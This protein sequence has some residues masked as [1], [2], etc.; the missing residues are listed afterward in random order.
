[1]GYNTNS[2]MENLICSIM[3]YNKGR[4]PCKYL[5]IALEEGSKSSKVCLDT[6]DKLDKRIGSWKDKWLSKA[7]K[8]TK[9][10]S[11]LS[12]IPTFPLSCLPLSKK[13]LSKFEGKLRNFLWKDCEDDTKLSLVKW[14][15]LC[16]PKKFGG[17]GVKN[18]QWKNEALGVKIIWH[19]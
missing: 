11:I 12:A 6:L 1:M 10:S 4:F 15:N 17:S 14:D 19:L 16:K 9:I 7:R 13:S 8:T 5:G 3:G 2:K 18:L